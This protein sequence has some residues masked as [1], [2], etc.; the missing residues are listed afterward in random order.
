M[1]LLC[2]YNVDF[3]ESQHNKAS[4]LERLECERNQNPEML[5][6]L[7]DKDLSFFH[8]HMAEYLKQDENDDNEEN[9]QNTDNDSNINDNEIVDQVRFV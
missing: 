9:D 6:G 1:V 7:K 3:K 8:L 4:Y 2:S 5:N